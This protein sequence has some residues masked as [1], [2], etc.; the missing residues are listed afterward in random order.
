[1]M[2]K[3]REKKE[4][5]LKEN[6]VRKKRVRNQLIWKNGRTLVPCETVYLVEELL[7]APIL[8]YKSVNPLQLTIIA[9]YYSQ[10]V[11]I[12]TIAGVWKGVSRSMGANKSCKG[13]KL[14]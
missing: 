12:N 2:K 6:S 3:L 4:E 9:C 5:E 14:P 8:H 13:K 10:V 1:M 11:V 7:H